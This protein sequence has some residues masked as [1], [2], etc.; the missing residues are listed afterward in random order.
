M[1]YMELKNV[2]Y[3]YPLAEQ[4]ALK[5]INYHFEQGKLYGIIGENGGG[6]TTFCDLMKGL[7]P[8]FYGG[9]LT[10]EVFIKGK[11]I[12]DWE[13]SELASS[14][15]YIFQNPFTQ[16]SG[17]KE[18]VFE[19]I[20]LGLENLGVEREEIIERV[21]NVVKQLKIEHLIKNNPN[22][23]SG[24]QRQRV[25]FASIIAMETD[26]LVIDEPTSQL[27][28]KGT[29][30]I[31]EIIHLLKEQGKT[32]LLVEH[33][34]DLIAE[35]ADEVLVIKQG[36]LI[37]SGKTS[38]VFSN[39]ELLNEGVNIPQIALLS[40]DMKEHGKPFETFAITKSQA[41][42]QILKKGSEKICQ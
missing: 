39:V 9:D 15:G 1:S 41:R 26:I 31:F 13:S 3:R 14:I 38:E 25:A 11:E 30:D 33:K 20:A 35:Y 5:N 37:T 27:D 29:S 10:G 18:T 21:T 36:E 4:D 6:K 2:T 34:I 16:I 17:I 40:N 42:E 24:G 32:I 28:P 23:L 19:E 22:K 8:S 12:R 7:I